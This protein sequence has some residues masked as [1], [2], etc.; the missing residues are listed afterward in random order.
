[1][2]SH[3]FVSGFVLAAMFGLSA[4]DLLAQPAPT[5]LVLRFDAGAVAPPAGRTG[6]HPDEFQF[7]APG[8]AMALRAAGIAYLEKVFPAFRSQDRFSTN[9]AGESVL[10]DDLSLFYSALVTPGT[11]EAQIRQLRSVSGIREVGAPQVRRLTLV[12]NDS[13]F[14]RQ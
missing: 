8:V 5:S 9:L 7:G 4:P 14:T 10:L 1:M 6:G 2:S 11:S 13:L 3:G 12:P